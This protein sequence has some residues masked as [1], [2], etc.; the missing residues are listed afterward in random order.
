MWIAIEFGLLSSIFATAA[1]VLV[2]HGVFLVNHGADYY[3]ATGALILF[4]T[5][6]PLFI[7]LP[8]RVFLDVPRDKWGAK[9]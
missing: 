3:A 2:Y 4:M 8:L 7:S 9:G 5:L 1:C 6:G